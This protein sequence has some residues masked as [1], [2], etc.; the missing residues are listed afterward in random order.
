MDPKDI[1]KEYT[2]GEI[3]V[4]WQSVKCTHSGNCVRN[5]PEVFQPKNNPWVKMENSSTEKI[6]E[7]VNKC[8]SGALTYQKNK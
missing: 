6:I 5:N 3:T 7:T 8:P 4:I 2:N 1:K